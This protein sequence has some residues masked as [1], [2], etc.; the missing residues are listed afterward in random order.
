MR[1]TLATLASVL[2]AMPAAAG[3]RPVAPPPMA[4]QPAQQFAVNL[5]NVAAQV[6]QYHVRQV[7][8]PELT[9]AAL[10]GLYQ[11]AR[12]PVPSDLRERLDKAAARGELVL[13]VQEVHAQTAGA[14]TALGRDPM[15]VACQAMLRSLDP[16]SGVLGRDELRRNVAL[17]Q[18]AQGIGVALEEYTGSGP[19][20]VK[21]VYPGGPAQRAGVRPGDRI[22]HVEDIPVDKPGADMLHAAG[23]VK[24]LLEAPPENALR[25]LAG[26]APPIQVTVLRP[27]G[28]PRTVELERAPFRVE[29]VLGTGRDD[30]HRWHYWADYKR[31]IA[32][33]RVSMLSQGTADELG[34][35]LERLHAAGMRGLVLDLRWTPGGYLNDSVY[36][37]RLFLGDVTVATVK[38]RTEGDFPHRGGGP[39][40]LAD[41]PLAA[42]VNGETSGGAELIAAALQDHKRAIVVGQRT[43]GKASVQTPLDVPAEGGLKMKLTSGTFFRPSGKNLHRFPDSKA[44]DDW[45]VKPNVEFRVSPDLSR[46][47]KAWWLAQTLRPGPSLE[48]LPLDDPSNDPQRQAAV[49]V[50]AGLIGKQK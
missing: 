47:L 7:P 5:N 42:L 1:L 4:G 23:L 29:T 9:H 26:P 25:Q 8:V 30:G 35:V 49:D 18:E 46:Q 40:Q 12:L 31:R 34:D 15:A 39:S 33:V 37:A 27:R 28:W 20:V 22:T 41:L 6:N 24:L 14:L 3:P 50:V 17:D 19:L 36:A 45:G 2:F 48:R 32:H 43:L 21:D 10:A 13:V 44:S 38:S 16:W 11:G